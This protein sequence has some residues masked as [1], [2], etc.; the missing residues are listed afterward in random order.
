MNHLRRL[1][2]A[3]CRSCTLAGF[4]LSASLVFA[5]SASTG[6]VEGRVLNVTSGR[7]IQNARVTIEGTKLETSTDSAGQVRLLDVPAGL[8]RVR[9]SYLG[10][11]P[12]EAALNIAAG[13]S[14]TRDFRLGRDAKSEADDEAAANA[15]ALPAW[16]DAPS[17]PMIEAI[18]A[19]AINKAQIGD[20]NRLGP[21]ALSS[22]CAIAM[23]GRTTIQW[24]MNLRVGAVQAVKAIAEMMKI[25]SRLRGRGRIALAYRK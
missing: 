12:S 8:A 13:Q 2:T 16:E 4:L 17:R 22:H 19:A 25:K 10:L 3:L 7:Y 15:A 24:I 6:T 5:Q 23:P 21:K 11:A 1:R 14:A 18:K 20:L 9:V